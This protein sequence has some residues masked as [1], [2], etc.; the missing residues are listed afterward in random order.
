VA[1]FKKV[2]AGQGA[3][4]NLGPTLARKY[5]GLQSAGSYARSLRESFGYP[6]ALAGVLVADVETSSPAEEE[7]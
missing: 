5:F 2:A 3:R 1:E 4:R 7:E 6:A